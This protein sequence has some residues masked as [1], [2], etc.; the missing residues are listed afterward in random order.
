[1]EGIC[2]AH[3]CGIGWDP[4][5]N[6]SASRRADVRWRYFS[7]LLCAHSAARTGAKTRERQ[8]ESAYLSRIAK[9][10]VLGLC[11]I[12]RKPH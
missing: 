6:A 7:G 1:R 5:S 10:E 2:A 8:L 11:N 3:E 9:A 4:Q 12:K